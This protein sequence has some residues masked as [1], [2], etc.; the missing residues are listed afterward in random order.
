[1]GLLGPALGSFRA[2]IGAISG[3]ALGPDG[4]QC[5]DTMSKRFSNQPVYEFDML[6]ILPRVRLNDFSEMS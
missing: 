2:C 4:L 6:L 3:P 5:T 1:M